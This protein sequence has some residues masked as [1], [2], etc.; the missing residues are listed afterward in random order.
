MSHKFKMQFE[1]KKS[2]RKF[3]AISKAGAER[4]VAIKARPNIHLVNITQK[5]IFFEVGL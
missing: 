3:K 5:L 4:D 1:V 2:T